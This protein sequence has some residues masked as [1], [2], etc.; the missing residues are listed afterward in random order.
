MLTVSGDEDDCYSMTDLNSHSICN[1]V[2]L[3]WL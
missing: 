2:L 3:M 1:V